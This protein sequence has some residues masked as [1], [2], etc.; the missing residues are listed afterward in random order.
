MELRLQTE[1]E[2]IENYNTSMQQDFPPAEIKPLQTILRLSK[3]GEYLCYG[4]YEENECQAYA[5]FMK[6]PSE[7]VM[8][9]DYFAVIQ[10]GRG[11]GIGSRVLK[12][13]LEQVGSEITVIIEAEDPA[14]AEDKEQLEIR[15]RRIAFYQKNGMLLTDITAEAFGV[16]FAILLNHSW[17]TRKICSCYLDI[18]HAMIAEKNYSRVKILS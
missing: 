3:A 1:S 10:S 12:A 16:V 6:H 14:Q 15:K 7:P 11:Q 17:D 13:V 4:A 9:L 18:Y 2:I 8:L 5:Y